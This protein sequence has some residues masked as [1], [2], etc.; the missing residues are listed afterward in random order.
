VPDE[1][2]R[3]GETANVMISG[4]CIVSG[5]DIRMSVL[6]SRV[7]V[8][9]CCRIS[10]AVVLPEC[11]IGRGAR[12][13]KVVIDRGCRIPQGL[14]IG[15]DAELDASRFYRTDSGVVLVTTAM[16]ERLAR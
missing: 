16:L 4:G 5:S 8:H 15:E 11:D 6:F 7:R 2:G 12:L 10:Q 3:H 1:T 9:S 14:V 13:S